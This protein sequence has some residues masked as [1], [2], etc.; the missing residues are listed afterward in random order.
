MELSKAEI[1]HIALLSR[2]D[3][4]EDEKKSFS[5]QLSDILAYFEK[6]K[7]VD[8]EKVSETARVGELCNVLCDDEVCKSDV[9]QEELLSNTPDKLDAYFKVKTVLE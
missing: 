6:L 8:T 2:I 5:H 7:E 1:E 3:I 4:T 9:T